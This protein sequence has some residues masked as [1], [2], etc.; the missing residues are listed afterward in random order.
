MPAYVIVHVDVKDPARY[1]E[2]KKMS[3]ISIGR[4]GGR[5]MSRGGK[6]EVLEGTWEPKRL[7]LLEFPSVEAA[8]RW[9]ASED[10]APAKALRQ[11][12][13]TGDLVV[14]EGV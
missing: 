6:V 9:H 14:I 10:Y 2:Y 3:P 11:A 13:S 12:T 4:F 1:E 5:F 7:V 8:R